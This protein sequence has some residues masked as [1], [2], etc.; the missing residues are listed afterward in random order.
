MWQV[1]PQFSYWGFPALKV[2]SLN[3]WAAREAPAL[4][5]LMRR[6]VL[7]VV[8]SVNFLSPVTE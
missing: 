8:W 1:G 6:C 2:Q 7:S 3:R 4:T 5:V